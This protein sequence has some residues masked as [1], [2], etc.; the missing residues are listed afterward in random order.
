MCVYE[1]LGFGELQNTKGN[2]A[3]AGTEDSRHSSED[4][5]TERSAH[6]DS[7]KASEIQVSPHLRS[8]C[9]TS[10]LLAALAGAQIR[11]RTRLLLASFPL[12]SYVSGC[13]RHLWQGISDGS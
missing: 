8:R 6:G 2:K 12:Y 4:S 9:L 3:L 11:R 13:H 1:G 7:R 5:G 10:V